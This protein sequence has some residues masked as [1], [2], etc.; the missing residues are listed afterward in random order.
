MPTRTLE[1]RQCK[2][3]LNNFCFLY[4]Y[5]EFPGNLFGSSV[6]YR[7]QTVWSVVATERKSGICHW[8]V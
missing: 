1:K 3:T 7:R 4:L 2:K 6:C 5:K 8:R